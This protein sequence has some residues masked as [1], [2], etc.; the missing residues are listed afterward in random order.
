MLASV[1][2]VPRKFVR[3]QYIMTMM[4][5]GIA[6]QNLQYCGIPVLRYNHSQGWFMLM[7]EN[8]QL[9]WQATMP[10]KGGIVVFHSLPLELPYLP[11]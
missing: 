6:S 10:V 1:K 5:H 8:S 9:P 3:V 7:E 4:C 2:Y 11:G